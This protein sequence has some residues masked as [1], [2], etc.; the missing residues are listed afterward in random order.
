MSDK[1]N[2]IP[3]PSLKVSNLSKQRLKA[4]QLTEEM[5]KTKAFDLCNHL[6]EAVMMAGAKELALNGFK[7]QDPEFL[8][9][10]SFA[11]EALRSA[12][13]RQ[14]GLHHAFQ[15]L[16]DRYC[17]HNLVTNKAGEVVKVG[18]ELMIKELEED[19]D[20]EPEGPAE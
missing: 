17:K 7:V 2:I 15:D 1:D 10:F 13:M 18:L 8:K 19:H 11:L 9:D 6:S 4:E 20:D 3:F 16:N 5:K 14:Q 12:C